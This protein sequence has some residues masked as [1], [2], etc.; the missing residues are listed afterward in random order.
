MCRRVSASLGQQPPS[1][2]RRR[3][4]SMQ[5]QNPSPAVTLP[6][7]AR[8]RQAPCTTASPA[9]I[10][11]AEITEPTYDNNSQNPTPSM[12]P[13]PL[14]RR[15]RSPSW[16]GQTLIQD[17]AVGAPK[18]APLTTPSQISSCHLPSSPDYQPA[19]QCSRPSACPPANCHYRTRQA[20]CAKGA[21]PPRVPRAPARQLE[22]VTHIG[23]FDRR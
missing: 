9:Y 2:R 21:M 14:D 7:I 15:L 19:R 3:H 17:E 13:L 4:C 16:L 6:R 5:Y 12:P 11:Q 8:L 10:I 23:E 18:A 1:H 20:K 22:L